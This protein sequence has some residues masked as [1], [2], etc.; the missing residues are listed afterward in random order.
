MAQEEKKEGVRT[1]DWAAMCCCCVGAAFA[2]PRTCAPTIAA[3]CVNCSV[4]YFPNRD[5]LW[6]RCVLAFPKA[7]NSGLLCIIRV[8][9]CPPASAAAGAIAAPVLLLSTDGAR[10]TR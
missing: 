3:P 7:S 5:E 1:L 10:H 9:S 4:M 2:A 6:L 8:V